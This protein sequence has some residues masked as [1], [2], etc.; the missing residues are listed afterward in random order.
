MKT[1]ATANNWIKM[2]E[3]RPTQADLPVW[4]ANRNREVF[5]LELEDE[6]DWGYLTHWRHAKADIPEPP[7]EETQKE[8]DGA[9]FRL[10]CF[11][12]N[13]D[14]F[15]STD[16]IWHAALAYERAEVAKMLPVF[17]PLT[18]WEAVVRKSRES[19]ESIRAR[20]EGGAK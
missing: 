11:C 17:S 2:T 13:E 7:K 16:D 18:N 4:C 10:W 12:G 19:L 3:R 9:A 8:K 20:C 1:K 6:P 14:A 5:L 15:P